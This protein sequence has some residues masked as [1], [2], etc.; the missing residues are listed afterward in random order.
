MTRVRLV[1]DADEWDSLVLNFPDA[2]VRQSYAWGEVRA[3]VGWRPVR[4][5]AFDGPRCVAAMGVLARRLPG[6]GTVLDA[7][8]GPLLDPESGAAWVGLRRLLRGVGAET[9]AVLLR[10]SP[11][12][13]AE[14]QPFARAL[15]ACGLRPLDGAWTDWNLPRRVM[16]LP[17]AGTEA[18]VLRRM[19]K[20]RRRR[21][22]ANREVQVEVSPALEGVRAFYALLVTHARVRGYPIRAWSYFAALHRHFAPTGGV[23]V[24]L[25]R[26]RGEVV[27]AQ[28][29]LRFGPMALAINAPGTLTAR[30]V[31]ATE[32][33]QWEWIRWAKAAGCETID[34]G[35]SATE[36]IAR[37]KIEMGCDPVLCVPY[38]DCPYAPL[39]YRLVR[40]AEETAFPR[41]RPL[42]A[43]ACRALRRRSTPAPLPRPA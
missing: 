4:M 17:L 9:R 41:L 28:I 34:F 37:F 33:V 8:R 2:D 16:R 40:F 12:V 23:V 43:A 10:L 6:F 30:G 26:V 22:L 18:D 42:A 15:R 27:S 13:G 24:V 32:V 25:G 5:A 3:E 38:F 20:P 21:V 7:P 11:G 39:R 35:P 1:A 36:G 29:G 31:A 14:H 19:A